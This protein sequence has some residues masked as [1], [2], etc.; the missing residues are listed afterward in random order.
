LKQL[1]DQDIRFGL[2]M[3]YPMG[4]LLSRF[5][6]EALNVHIPNGLTQQ[7][8]EKLKTYANALYGNP[9]SPQ[10]F[11]L[12]R[13]FEKSGQLVFEQCDIKDF[14]ITPVQNGFELAKGDI[15]RKFSAL[16]NSA[17]Y[18]MKAISDQGVVALP[19]LDRLS[20]RNALKRHSF[21]KNAFAYG[22]QNWPELYLA[23]PSCN[24]QRWGA[25][26]FRNSLGEIA[27]DSIANLSHH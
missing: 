7:N 10:R 3:G 15:N 25:E 9:T 20:K 18:S 21:D 8:F 23:G 22:Q 16:F 27:L 14:K 1:F 19:L 5:N 26:T 12:M 11:D 24:S 13:K 17:S 2:N 4:H 6:P